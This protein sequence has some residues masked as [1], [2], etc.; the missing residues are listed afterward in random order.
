MHFLLRRGPTSKNSWFF[1]HNFLPCHMLPFLVSK[2]AKEETIIN[3]NDGAHFLWQLRP[4]FTNLVHTLQRGR[5][6]F[7]FSF[8]LQIKILQKNIR[9]PRQLCRRY[10]FI[11]FYCL[12][13]PNLSASFAT[14]QRWPLSHLRI[15]YQSL[16]ECH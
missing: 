6:V 13:H 1:M 11:F 2:Q 8:I 16:V 5:F 15:S 3:R 7:N 14:N 9:N 4:V 12:A 10:L